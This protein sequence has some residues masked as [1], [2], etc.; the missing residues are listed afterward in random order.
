MGAFIGSTIMLA[1][2]VYVENRLFKIQKLHVTALMLG[3]SV[4][5]FWLS[6]LFKMI[7]LLVYAYGSLLETY[8]SPSDAT[9]D[10]GPEKRDL[11]G[12]WDYDINFEAEDE[13]TFGM[14]SSNGWENKLYPGIGMYPLSVAGEVFYIFA[15]WLMLFKIML[16]SKGLTI[17]RRRLS[18]KSL[19]R[20]PLYMTLYLLFYLM[21]MSGQEIYY[22]EAVFKS[23][24]GSPMGVAL[25]L[26]RVSIGSLFFASVCHTITKYGAKRG[27]Y[28]KFL[29]FGFS[30]ILIFPI[31]FSI[32]AIIM[33]VDKMDDISLLIEGVLVIF[34][35]VP[36]MTIQ[37]VMLVMYDPTCK[38][39]NGKFPFHAKVKEMKKL[40]N[41]RVK[42]VGGDPADDDETEIVARWVNLSEKQI[43]LLHK[44]LDT[45]SFRLERVVEAVGYL[46]TE[47][48]DL[49]AVGF[50][51]NTLLDDMPDEEYIPESQRTRRPRRGRRDRDD[52]G[53]ESGD[54]EEGRGRGRRRRNRRDRDEGGNRSD[55]GSDS[56]A[57]DEPNSRRK[58]KPRRQ[59]RAKEDES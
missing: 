26:I 30:W 4:A 51:D 36:M 27:F 38:G 45:A 29:I 56:N 50:G 33:Y 35:L 53:S 34:N 59:R 11:S 55:E 25:L 18:S 52:S 13:Y 57:N 19:F 20:V 1:Y 7:H 3:V 42:I 22:D 54:E 58:R 14:R 48:D 8:P 40:K 43:T 37:I 17:T 21:Y 44:K 49:D 47:L 32:C 2:T 46:Q 31:T 28:R 10:V 15:D 23:K 9:R 6:T 39:L 12:M 16:V 41:A 5:C 24:Y